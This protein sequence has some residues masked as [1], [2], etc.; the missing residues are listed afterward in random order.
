MKDNNI[1]VV[2]ADKIQV[3]HGEIQYSFYHAELAQA[4]PKIG[5]NQGRENGV[6][7]GAG[8]GSGGLLNPQLGASATIMLPAD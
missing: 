3:V 6:N 7:N 5:G 1:L 2:M 4:L 8:G